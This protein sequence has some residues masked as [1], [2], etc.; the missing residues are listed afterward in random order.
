MENEEADALM[1]L[2]LRHFDP[3]ERIPAE[4]ESLEL[5]V[6]PMLFNCGDSYLADLEESGKKARAR[7]LSAEG[8]GLTRGDGKRRLGESLRERQLW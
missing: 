8:G 4:L 1:N 3:K 5:K 2:D 6:M 7:K